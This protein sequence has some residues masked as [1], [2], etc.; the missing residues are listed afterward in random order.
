MEFKYHRCRKRIFRYWPKYYIVLAY[1][2]Y[3]NNIV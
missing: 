3:V 2:V 1:K